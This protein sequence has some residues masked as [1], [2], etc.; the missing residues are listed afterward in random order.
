[1]HG[2]IMTPQRQADDGY[3][4]NALGFN[5]GLANAEAGSKGFR[6]GVKGIV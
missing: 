3:I 2:L 4:I 1:M 5:D 6:I